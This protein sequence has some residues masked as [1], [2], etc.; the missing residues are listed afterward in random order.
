MD[1]AGAFCVSYTLVEL[2]YL[3]V[4]PQVHL[5]LSNH[6]SIHPVVGSS[7]STL[8]SLREIHMSAHSA[9]S[10]LTIGSLDTV[11]ENRS[12]TKIV[13]GGIGHL[14]FLVECKKITRGRVSELLTLRGGL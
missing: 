2:R 12:L 4:L 14:F 7:L 8:P 9:L 13:C 10:S 5:Y 3:I 11:A 1:K 6:C